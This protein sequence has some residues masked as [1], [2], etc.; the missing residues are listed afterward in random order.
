M[1]DVEHELR[2]AAPEA[3]VESAGR[4][5]REVVRVD[6]GLG[7]RRAG[8]GRLP[9]IL[10]AVACIVALGMAVAV[11]AVRGGRGGERAAGVPVD[12]ARIVSP[13]P[14]ATD[15]THVVY[16]ARQRG[17][18]SEDRLATETWSL[19]CRQ[20]R[21]VTKSSGRVPRVV[22]TET[23]IGARGER[24]LFDPLTRTIYVEE[25]VERA[26]AEGDPNSRIVALRE[27]IATGQVVLVGQGSFANRPTWRLRDRREPDGHVIEID[28]ATGR[29]VLESQP[30]RGDGSEGLDY[31]SPVWEGLPSTAENLALL[32]VQA[33]H[34]GAK[35]E[36]VSQR[37][38]AE[39]SER[40]I[41]PG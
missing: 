4:R 20:R 12:L 22:R 32:D 16:R 39:I 17:G 31:E 24:Q 21:V 15:I 26:C 13:A 18:T 7:T 40:L 28:K 10:A 14:S 6:R 5:V 27:G 19:G 2:R 38:F 35:V 29:P 33:A 34:P 37:R 9:A 1:L 3:D 23:A 11:V 41:G 30:P 36:T 8:R 25:N